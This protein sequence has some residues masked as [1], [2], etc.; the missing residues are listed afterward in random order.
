MA[1]QGMPAGVKLSRQSL[2]SCRMGIKPGSRI[3][4]W[5]SNAM[6]PQVVQPSRWFWSDSRVTGIVFGL[7][8]VPDV[9]ANIRTSVFGPKRARV[10]P[11]RTLSM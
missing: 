6:I 1:P 2:V 9:R 5:S 4:G 8:V 3:A 7:L 10:S 11:L